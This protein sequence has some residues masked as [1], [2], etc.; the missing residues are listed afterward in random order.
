MTR[1]P[2]SGRAE[3]EVLRYITDHCPVTV[4]EA[5][6]GLY[7]YSPAQ[8]AAVAAELCARFR[9]QDA[10]RVFG[11]VRRLPCRK[12]ESLGERNY[13]PARNNYSVQKPNS[14]R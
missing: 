11:A 2:R 6:D 12:A 3:A 13:P 14:E 1:K 4:R 10:R 5:A 9:R 7:R 8:P